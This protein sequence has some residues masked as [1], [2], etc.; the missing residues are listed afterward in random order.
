MA[1]ELHHMISICRKEDLLKGLG[2]S[3]NAN[4]VKNLQ[5]ADDTLVF[6]QESI[7]QSV[8]LKWVLHCFEKWS[9]LKINYHKSSSLIFLVDISV[10]SFLISLIFNSLVQKLPVTYL[11][12]PLCTNKLNKLQ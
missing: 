12:L 4:V 2:C 9:G 3:D 6:G 5:Y 11:G 1:D 10:N 8:V 7:T